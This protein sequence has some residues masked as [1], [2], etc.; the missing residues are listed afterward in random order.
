MI[1]AISPGSPVAEKN[2]ICSVEQKARVHLY[3]ESEKF[4]KQPRLKL[5]KTWWGWGG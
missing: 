1:R 5:R 3:E 4:E 2:R